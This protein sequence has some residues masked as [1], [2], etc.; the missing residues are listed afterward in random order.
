MK[1]KVDAY[2]TVNTLKG[3]LS[4]NLHYLARELGVSPGARTEP[5]SW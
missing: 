1:E 4:S 3:Q 5:S 2:G